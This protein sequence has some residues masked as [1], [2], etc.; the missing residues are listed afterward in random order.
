MHMKKRHIKSFLCHGG[1][2]LLV[3]LLIPVFGPAQQK[4][5]TMT[6]SAARG[7]A[8]ASLKVTADLSQRLA[9]F[10]RVQMQFQRASLST[11]EQQLVRKLVEACGYLERIYCRQTDHQALALYPSL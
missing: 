1:V 7:P 2:F 5:K 9:R 11:R 8:T 6:G 4:K 3:V 10:L